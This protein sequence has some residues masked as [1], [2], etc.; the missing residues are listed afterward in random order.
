MIGSLGEPF[1]DALGDSPPFLEGDDHLLRVLTLLPSER[2]EEG[3]EVVGNIVLNGG[4]VADG[5]NGAERSTIEAKMGVCFES[6]AIGLDF[7]LGGYPFAEFSL[8][9]A[10]RPEAETHGQFFG[11]TFAL[12]VLLREED[13][14]WSDLLNPRV[15]QDFDLV[16]GKS[17]FSKFGERLIVGIKD[18]ASTLDEMHRDFVP[19]DLGEGSAQVFVEQVEQ[20][21]SKFNAGWS[22]AADDE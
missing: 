10:G 21:R 15:C 3:N 18:V 5:V 4:A 13:L 8:C 20:L 19:E 1:L 22:A 6:V 7:E 12:A 9:D 17:G 11:D 16:M 2:A 14:V